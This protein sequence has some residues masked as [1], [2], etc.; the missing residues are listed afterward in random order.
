M[1][2]NRTLRG[3]VWE[4]F[5]VWRRL[6]CTIEPRL[7]KSARLSALEALE[8][9]MLAADSRAGRSGDVATLSYENRCKNSGRA[10]GSAHSEAIL[11]C[12]AAHTRVSET[13]PLEGNV[14]AKA[15]FIAA[16]RGEAK[17]HH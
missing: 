10:R 13:A 17:S 14:P 16:C 12:F 11:V 6:Y 5:A 1:S 8:P 3:E 9:R 2:M 7:H 15:L 4:C